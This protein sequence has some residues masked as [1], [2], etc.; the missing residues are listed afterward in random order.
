MPESRKIV[1]LED[2][3]STCA[4]IAS[5]LEKA[6][7]IVFQTNEGRGAVEAVFK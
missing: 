6:G 1:V 7:Y 4:L 3:R 2:D 5:V